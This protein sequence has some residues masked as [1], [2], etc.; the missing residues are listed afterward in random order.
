MSPEEKGPAA[1]ER[2]RES[3]WTTADA[4]R[5]AIPQLEAAGVDTP[6]FDAQLLLGWAL[7]GQSREQLASAPER[8]LTRREWV[9]FEK[10]VAL[11]A[12]RRP[13]PYITGEAWFYGREFKIN[14]AVLIPRPETEMLV[15]FALEKLAGIVQPRIADIGTG[16]GCVAVSIACEMPQAQVVAV[17]ISPLALRIAAKNVRRH[18]VDSR[19]ELREGDLCGPLANGERFD[20]IVSNP[21][22]VPALDAPTLA[23]EVRDYEPA[24]ALYG[25]EPSQAAPDL[26]RTLRRR[27]LAEAREH[28]TPGG[29]IALEIGVNQAEEALAD[30]V[31]VDYALPELRLDFA[32]IPRILVAQAP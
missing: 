1:F 11:R 4:L 29:W 18:Q 19:V 3:P 31:E 2:L 24:L 16:S 12:K 25:S 9:I 22:Y 8:L 17:D 15:E 21:P 28:L 7:G 20:V 32:A 14:R 27:L 26:P 30:A 5:L 13:L 10:A 6:R 23:P